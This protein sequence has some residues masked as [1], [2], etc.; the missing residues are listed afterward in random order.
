MHCRRPAGGWWRRQSTRRSEVIALGR[1]GTVSTTAV[2][3]CVH[4]AHCHH[5]RQHHTLRQPSRHRHRWHFSVLPRRTVRTSRLKWFNSPSSTSGR[6]D[7]FRPRPNLHSNRTTWRVRLGSTMCLVPGR[8]RYWSLHAV[9]TMVGSEAALSG[10]IAMSRCS[11][12]HAIHP[13]T[14]S[15]PDPA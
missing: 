15:L 7:P 10:A 1:T 11:R 3:H 13:R 2:T 14:K 9:S 8:S 6:Q 12:Y 4:P 5:Q